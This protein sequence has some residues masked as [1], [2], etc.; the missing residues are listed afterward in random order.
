MDSLGS[1][2]ADDELCVPALDTERR[3]RHGTKLPLANMIMRSEG[4]PIRNNRVH[5]NIRINCVEKLK[6]AGLG[7]TSS[8]DNTR[9]ERGVRG[10]A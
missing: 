8:R 3:N 7:T 2:Q 10:S 5:Q 4:R 9:G 1:R 6:Q